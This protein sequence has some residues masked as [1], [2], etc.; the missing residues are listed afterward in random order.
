MFTK[1]DTVYLVSDKTR[2]RPM[3]FFHYVP[4]GIGT[5]FFETELAYCTGGPNKKNV[6]DSRDLTL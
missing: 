1:G 6:Y 5:N 3:T 4:T 2:K